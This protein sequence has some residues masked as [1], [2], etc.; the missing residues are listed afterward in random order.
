MTKQASGDNYSTL[1]QVLPM[2]R[3]YEEMIKGVKC[4]SN[5]ALALQEKMLSE[6]EKRFGRIEKIYLVAAATILDPH[7]KQIHFQDPVACSTTMTKMRMR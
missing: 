3:C 7:F 1:S 5:E 2:L 4:K 6:C